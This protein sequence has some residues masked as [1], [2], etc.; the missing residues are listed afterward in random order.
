MLQ[1]LSSDA[2]VIGALRVNCHKNINSLYAG[3]FF[4]LLWLSADFFKLNFFK[5]F[6]Q[7]HYQSVKKELTMVFSEII[8]LKLTINRFCLTSLSLHPNETW[9][10]TGKYE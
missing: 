5:K 6:F 9:V 1:T 4:M 2:V 7:E 8:N 3:Q 10:L